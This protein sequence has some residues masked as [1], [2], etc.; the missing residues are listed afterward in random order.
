MAARMVLRL[1]TASGVDVPLR[2][3]FERQ[4]VAG[5]AEAVDALGWLA[6]SAR[7][8]ATGG[9]R[10]RWRSSCERPDVSR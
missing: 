8:V 2:V 1:R 9:G 3:L 6:A 4:T 7:P 5:L 10:D